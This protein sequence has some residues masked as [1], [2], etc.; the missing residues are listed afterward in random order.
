MLDDG[1]G[2]PGLA[3]LAYPEHGRATHGTLAARGRPS[4]LQRDLLGLID[5]PMGAALE[6]VGLHGSLHIN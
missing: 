5:V 6:T 4:V 2:E 1:P 3:G